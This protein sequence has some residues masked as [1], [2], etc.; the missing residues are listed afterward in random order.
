MVWE[1]EV[2][3]EADG[4]FESN[5]PAWDATIGHEDPEFA[6]LWSMVVFCTLTRQEP[7]LMKFQ[8]A[9]ANFEYWRDID[10]Q[11]ENSFLDLPPETL[12]ELAEFIL[13]AVQ[14]VNKH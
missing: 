5:V 10:E 8:E 9:L 4:F 1:E 12:D 6:A 3:L 7:P 14:E 13:A 2:E 11:P